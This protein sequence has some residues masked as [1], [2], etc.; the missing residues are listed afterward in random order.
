MCHWSI[1]T[2]LSNADPNV[3]SSE[4]RSTQ[5]KSLDQTLSSLKFH[6]SES[7]WLVVHSVADQADVGDLTVAKE[8]AEILVVDV[9]G[10]VANMSGIW[11]LVGDRKLLPWWECRV[12][13]GTILGSITSVPITVVIT[14]ITRT[15]G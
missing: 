13:V 14:S 11:G 5:F 3:T 2:R 9:E 1:L 4:L 15:G 7:L 12:T 8:S 10:K 6:I